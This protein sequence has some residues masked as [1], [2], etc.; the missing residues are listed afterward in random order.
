MQKFFLDILNKALMFDSSTLTCNI[1][2]SSMRYTVK[3]TLIANQSM[4]KVFFF[5]YSK[6][7]FDVWLLYFDLQ[8]M[9]SDPNYK[10]LPDLK[11]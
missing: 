10:K 4:Q 2:I 7:S 1:K 9:P 5:G 11:F 8:A 3:Y 6:Q